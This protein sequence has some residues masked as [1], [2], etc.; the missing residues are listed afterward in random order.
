MT[1]EEIKIHKLT[2]SNTILNRDKLDNSHTYI[3]NIKK[4]YKDI[5]GSKGIKFC[6]NMQNQQKQSVKKK[7]KV[8]F[9]NKIEYSKSWKVLIKLTLEAYLI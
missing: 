8:T 5:Y 2:Q 3:K 4:D 6:D 9:T 1:K 7:N